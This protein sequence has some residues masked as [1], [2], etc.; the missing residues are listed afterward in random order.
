LAENACHVGKSGI[1]W[2][3]IMGRM[4][5]KFWGQFS[6]S[7]D[8]KNRVA[9]P[10][11]FRQQ[12]P[13]GKVVVRESFEDCLAV[14]PAAEWEKRVEEKLADLDEIDSKRN[15]DIRRMM[16]GSVVECELDRQG[17]ICLSSEHVKAVG[18]SKEVVIRGMHDSFEIWDRKKWEAYKKAYKKQWE[19]SEG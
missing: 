7:L 2:G 6:H 15:R 11:K 19:E 3:T 4:A 16:F 13:D 10:A 14:H 8:S 17:R 1:K 5:Y 9:I 12:L 18:I